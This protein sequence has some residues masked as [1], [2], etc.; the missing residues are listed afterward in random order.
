MKTFFKLCNL[1]FFN[2]WTRVVFD[3]KKRKVQVNFF[4]VSIDICIHTISKT[5]NDFKRNIQIQNII[6]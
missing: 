2:Q 4:V 6:L 1:F 5:Y 3:T